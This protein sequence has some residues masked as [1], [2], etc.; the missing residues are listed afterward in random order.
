MFGRLPVRRGR[1]EPEPGGEQCEPTVRQQ[2]RSL[3]THRGHPPHSG[4][5]PG[6]LPQHGLGSEP[7][8]PD[9]CAGGFPHGVR[10]GPAA[11]PWP[12]A[13]VRSRAVRSPR[14]IR[15]RNASVI[16]A[17][18]STT[19]RGTAITMRNYT[20]ALR[21]SGGCG[22]SNAHPRPR[23]PHTRSTRATRVSYRIQV[24][25]SLRTT[26]SS[27]SHGFTVCSAGGVKSVYFFMAQ[28]MP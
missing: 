27:L 2:R 21:S 25:T 13:Y 7:T 18:D 22:D 20:A 15:R 11:P 28:R 6:H 12:A 10:P 4:R 26:E 19:F 8:R 23:T 24:T 9:R 1:W 5:H 3:A 14:M 16:A 17:W